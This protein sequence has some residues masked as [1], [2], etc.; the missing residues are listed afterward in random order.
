M[1][2]HMMS[3]RCISCHAPDLQVNVLRSRC[4]PLY[5]AGL[6]MRMIVRGEHL[7]SRLMMVQRM[8]TI[9]PYLGNCTTPEFANSTTVITASL[10]PEFMLYVF[11]ACRVLVGIATILGNVMVIICFAKFSAVRSTSNYFLLSLAFADVVSGPSS[12]LA[13]IC[14]VAH[15]NTKWNMHGLCVIAVNLNA[16]AFAGS[17][18]SLMGVACERYIKVIYSLR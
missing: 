5:N 13:V 8:A 11:Y 17:A 10:L 18:F 16:M 14:N 15:E 9:L 3:E 7:R 4:R 6:L 1:I 12:L 2:I